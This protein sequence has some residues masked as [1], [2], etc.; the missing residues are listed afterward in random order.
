[1]DST[2]AGHPRMSYRGAEVECPD[3][4]QSI[5]GDRGQTVEELRGHLSNQGWSQH[6]DGKWRCAECSENPG[7]RDPFF[8]P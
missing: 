2:A 4:G 7:S 8:S 3:C 6:Q 5:L 1:M